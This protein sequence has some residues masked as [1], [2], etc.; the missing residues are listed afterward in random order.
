MDR[1]ENRRKNY[2]IYAKLRDKRKLTDNQVHEATGIA[3]ATLSEWKKGTYQ[4]KYE[5]VKIL[6][7]FFDTTVGVIIRYNTH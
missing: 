6:A 2:E 7:D 4:P 1:A 3:T 5:K